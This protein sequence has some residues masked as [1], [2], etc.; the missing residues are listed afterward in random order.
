MKTQH[1]EICLP[2]KVDRV[3]IE[4][5]ISFFVVVG[6]RFTTLWDKT[7]ELSYL[8]LEVLLLK[9]LEVSYS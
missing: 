9:Y 7:L 2:H 8:T 4:S 1:V 3:K 6:L 5:E